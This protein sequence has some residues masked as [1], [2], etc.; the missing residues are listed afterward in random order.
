[1]LIMLLCKINVLVGGIGHLDHQFVV[2]LDS[3]TLKYQIK[4]TPFIRD[5]KSFCPAPFLFDVRPLF[6]NSFF[7]GVWYF[8][9]FF[10]KKSIHLA[11]N[12]DYMKLLGGVRRIP[13]IV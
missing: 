11:K 3:I 6:S 10:T 4:G 5:Q 13:Q 7:G 2:T 8:Y 1:M 12:K 9:H